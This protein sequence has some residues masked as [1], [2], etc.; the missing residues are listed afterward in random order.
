MLIN[1]NNL[2]HCPI[3]D[4][5]KTSTRVIFSFLFFVACIP[6]LASVFFTFDEFHDGW[7]LSTIQQTRLS[8]DTGGNYPSNQYG[9][10]WAIFG[11]VISKPFPLNNTL[12]VLRCVVLFSYFIS[13]YL[14]YKIASRVFNV[15]VAI[16]A[17]IFFE[18]VQPFSSG[19]G[20]VT[21][22]ST[23]CI[24]FLLSSLLLMISGRDLGQSRGNLNI[25]L[26]G[27]L[28]IPIIFSRAQIGILLILF[29]TIFFL[30]NHEY[31]NLFFFILGFTLAMISYFV[32]LVY[33][34]WLGPSLNDEFRLG[35]LYVT[36]NQ[37]EGWNSKP[38]FTFLFTS[39]FFI[40]FLC[41]RPIINFYL[42]RKRLF[43]L[44]ISLF[45]FFPTIYLLIQGNSLIFSFILAFRRFWI[46]MLLG[47]ILFW[48]FH[49]IRKYRTFEDKQ[50]LLLIFSIANLSQIYPL[51]DHYHVWWGAAP[52]VILLASNIGEIFLFISSFTFF[53]KQISQISS[54]CFTVFSIFL[55]TY[56]LMTPNYEALPN[57]ISRFI[58]S[59]I[60][61]ATKFTELNIF[62]SSNITKGSTVLNMCDAATFF[63]LN[64]NF[65]SSSRFY[66]LTPNI[67]FLKDYRREVIE[68][69]PR[70]AIL[71]NTS[72]SDR[73][74]L[75]SKQ[76]LMDFDLKWRLV[77]TFQTSDNQ[78]WEILVNI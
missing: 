71:C 9:S 50:K 61:T 8:I 14:I 6:I 24:V 27:V 60:N 21:W 32:F 4:Y 72:G 56:A 29:I 18:L 11:A 51:F 46:S 41:K 63:I 19:L 38:I 2:F 69:K 74:Y 33:L 17:V 10:F 34:G 28:L 35:L 53:R 3:I 55:A 20:F 15:N 47:S 30:L 16:I 62:F 42:I 68:T 37:F 75:L 67:L 45:F 70:Y 65:K 23:F 12:F 52:G 25:F 57:S 48:C 77:N 13:F 66:Y 7:I 58:K 39:V 76:L 22:P 1:I 54:V 31:Q 64:P 43:I 36:N 49:F 26:A 73:Q 78:I 44:S 59:D 40:V 5:M